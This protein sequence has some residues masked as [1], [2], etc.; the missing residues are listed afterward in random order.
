LAGADLLIVANAHGISLSGLDTIR[1]TGVEAL[2]A[3]LQFGATQSGL[4][5]VD[6]ELAITLNRLTDDSNVNA[7]IIYHHLPTDSD[8]DQLRSIGFI[9]GTRFRALPMVVVTGTRNQIIAASKLPAVR[10]IYGNRTLNLTSEPEVRSA[11]ERRAWHDSEITTRN[12]NVPV[13]G[14]TLPLPS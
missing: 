8:L 1:E 11:T 13:T 2:T 3:L 7:V 12:S 10:S 6:P 4:Q 5:S 14:R 9:G